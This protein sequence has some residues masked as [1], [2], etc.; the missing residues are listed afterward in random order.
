MAKTLVVGDMHL[1]QRIV[2][3]LVDEAVRASG[4]GRVVFTGDYTDEWGCTDA[5]ELAAL[6]CQ[7]AWAKTRRAEGLALD[8]L[9]GNH[10][11]HYLMASPAHYTHVTVLAPVAERL[12]ALALRP[13]ATAGGWLVTHAGVTRRWALAHG[14]PLG[15]AAEAAA[16]LNAMTETDLGMSQLFDCGPAR[17]G[18]GL[19]GPLWADLRELEG[20]APEGLDQ[21]V[22]HTPVVTCTLADTLFDAGSVIAC[23]TLS[24]ASDLRP[25]GD[26]S[27]LVIDEETGSVEAVWGDDWGDGWE[28]LVSDWRRG[29]V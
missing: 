22:G 4:A 7:L 17:G 26:A 27:M 24:L 28:S 14:V 2:L 29:L 19:P 25:I 11:W 16:A 20:D 3:P 13:A 5:D 1:K 15:G 8:F 10:D 9:A 18:S 6:D 12:L 21:I 23:D